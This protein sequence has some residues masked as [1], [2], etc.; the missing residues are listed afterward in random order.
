MD[1][2]PNKASDSFTLMDEGYSSSHVNQ[3]CKVMYG[4]HSNAHYIP[5][6]HSPELSNNSNIQPRRSIPDHTPTLHSH[7]NFSDFQSRSDLTTPNVSH[8]NVQVSDLSSCRVVPSVDFNLDSSSVPL[9]HDDDKMFLLS[10]LPY[11]KKFSE[12]RKLQARINVTQILHQM[13]YKQS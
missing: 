11:F 6:Q 8:K 9:E 3:F 1:A 7:R 5:E 2:E 10:L 13:L 12:E 4:S